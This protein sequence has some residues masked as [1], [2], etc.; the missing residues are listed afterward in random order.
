MAKKEKPAPR[1]RLAGKSHPGD[2]RVS[3]PVAM[4]LTLAFFVLGIMAHKVAVAR[5]QVVPGQLRDPVPATPHPARAI[6]PDFHPVEAIMLASMIGEHFEPKLLVNLVKALHRKVR[7]IILVSSPDEI[8]ACRSL[9]A[10]AGI[11]RGS[12]DLLR[13]NANSIWIRDYGPVFVRE[14]DGTLI[15]VESTY[16]RS[17][18]PGTAAANDEFAIA[19]GNLLNLRIESLPIR[20][21]G[22]NL[23]S[24]GR[25]LL[26]TTTQLLHA[27]QTRGFDGPRLSQLFRNKFGEMRWLMTPPLEGEPTGHAD[28]FLTFLSGDSVVVGRMDPASEPKNAARL[29]RLAS[30]LRDSGKGR[31]KVYRAPVT[32]HGEIWRSYCNVV[33]VNDTIL[34]PSFA[35][36][37]DAI[38]AEAMTV[39]REAAPHCEVMSIPCDSLLGYDGLLHCMTLAI[40]RGV[41]LEPLKSALIPCP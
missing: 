37:P 24:N 1:K 41:K 36:A 2:R 31:L 5:T 38:E 16:L 26:C 33:I 10:R 8:P 22:G 14:P 17:A 28:I 30:T 13:C 34:V 12:V 35:D 25:D 20:L 6:V 27:N 19:L 32:R 4:L 29:D 7:I 21:D 23:V 40:P 3:R 11:P 15:A 18:D 9:L 39:Y